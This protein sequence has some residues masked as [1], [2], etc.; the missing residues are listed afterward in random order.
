MLVAPV[1]W[2]LH[3]INLKITK[4]FLFGTSLEKLSIHKE[5]DVLTVWVCFVIPRVQLT[6]CC[7]S[8]A[9]SL[10]LL[11]HVG[12]AGTHCYSPNTNTGA[13]HTQLFLPPPFCR[14]QYSNDWS[15]NPCF[16]LLP[17]VQW[18][19][20]QLFLF[21]LHVQ[22]FV[23][24]HCISCGLISRLLCHFLFLLTI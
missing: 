22:F 24:L 7:S 12:P 1:T 16:I 23:L 18:L 6:N 15:P 11:K 4:T 19:F 10:I 21:N 17:L 14:W 5:S 13:H 2:F 20:G 9:P 3:L 8:S